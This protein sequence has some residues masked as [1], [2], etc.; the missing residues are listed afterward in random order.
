MEYRNVYFS[1][2][3]VMIFA[4][5]ESTLAYCDLIWIEMTI[6][7]GQEK[8]EIFLPNAVCNECF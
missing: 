4:C 6:F 8:K 2:I 7:G 5:H 1:T 3:I